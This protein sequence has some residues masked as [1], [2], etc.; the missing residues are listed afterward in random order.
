MSAL[1]RKL[2][3]NLWE[4]KGQVTAICLVIACGIATC[5]MSLST[6][7]SL[8]GTMERYY[9]Q[10]RF[11][12]V[13]ASLK[14]AP[15]ALGD[16]LAE[17]PGVA[18]VSPRVVQDVTLD[19]PGFDEPAVGRLISIPE[20]GAPPLNALHLRG[21]RWIE[22]NR[23]G[24]VLVN[25]A[26]ADVHHLRPG[27][28]V[29]AILNGRKRALTIVGT[30][31]TPEYIYQLREGEILPDDRRFG[32]FWI[33]RADV[34][35]AFDMEGAFNNVVLS[36]TREASLPDI[37][38]RVDDLIE[39]YGGLGSYDRSDQT[40]HQ[41]ITNEL[42][43][44]QTMG[45]MV[46]T[47]FLSVAA[48]LLNVVLS[49]LISTQREQIAALKALGYTGWEL[50]WHYVKLV[51]LIVVVGAILGTF[52]GSWM[53]QGLTEL[54]LQFYRFPLLEFQS[55]RRVVVGA[56]ALSLLAGVVGT[57]SA[58]RQAVR[59]PPA[60]AMRPSPP[61]DFRPTLIERLGLHWVFSQSGR[62]IL[63]NLERRPVK[64]FLSCLGIAMGIAVL[65]L[66]NF[67]KDSID[68]AMEQQFQRSQR[69]DM[70]VAFVEPLSSA[71]LHAV[72]HLP[73][74]EACQP[75]R[76]AA[77]RLR[78]GHHSRRVVVTGLPRD[79][80]LFLPVDIDGDVPP[81]PIEGLL[82]SRVL[83]DAL[84]VVPGDNVAMEVLER[85]RPRHTL[86]IAGVIDDFAGLSALMDL[87][88]LQRLLRCGDE[89]SG[90][91]L[92]V[93]ARRQR[94]LYRTLKS[95]PRVASVAVKDAAIQSF[96]QT[97][98][99]NLLRMQTF[100][101]IFAVIIALGVVYNSARVSFSERSRELATL[102]V[103]GFTR[104]EISVILLGE[105]AVLVLAAIPLGL[106]IG[107]GLAWW[108]T[109]SMVETE[110]FRI[111]LCIDPSTYA[112]AVLVI[113]AATVAS[114]LL[115]RRSLD[116]LDLI[117]VLK[118]RD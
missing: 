46:P 104:G 15:T 62:I 73:G 7:E 54:Y 11:G 84:G 109:Q 113:V 35:A 10:Y 115:V 107:T 40:S 90:A 4:L 27:D 5:V 106:G 116:Q 112:F 95:T 23:S 111:P 99:E 69:Q 93:D 105:L 83:A 76:T 91:Y 19:V 110:L 55:D 33:G 81:V 59:L 52:V 13:F 92:Q 65:I 12:Q 97:I 20:Y 64:A 100:N 96:E 48:F 66:G 16:R 103:I 85:D 82:V 39:P 31:I 56:F 78:S 101:V 42:T 102:R 21:G 26:F 44:L 49:R 88:R 74:V 24:E 32:L 77:V 6:M 53:G 70:T 57:F 36:V 25:E 22:P 1:D 87:D 75:F 37:L 80:E 3:R 51:L 72:E 45:T 71:A 89:H 67:M 28:S 47:I 108:S 98:A 34:A 43:Q 14:R 2:V 63:R 8:R 30:A 61:A 41:Y 86:R 50:G 117:G 94:E 114:G 29:Q 60:E 38:R 118:T 18:R 17:I 9:L 58:V 68:F 79:G